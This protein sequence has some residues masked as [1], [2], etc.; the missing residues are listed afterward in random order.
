VVGA[1]KG[2]AENE[3]KRGSREYPGFT[4][5]YNTETLMGVS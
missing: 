5:E 1:E 4:V 3:E 2:K